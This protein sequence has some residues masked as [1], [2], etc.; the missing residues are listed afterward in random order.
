MAICKDIDE[1]HAL[2]WKNKDKIDNDKI[3]VY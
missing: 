1:Y 2:S 3:E